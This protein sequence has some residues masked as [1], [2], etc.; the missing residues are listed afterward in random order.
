MEWMEFGDA[1]TGRRGLSVVEANFF[2]GSGNVSALYGGRYRLCRVFL[3]QAMA[4]TLSAAK[5]WE[6]NMLLT[7]ARTRLAHGQRF[8]THI[9]D[10]HHCR[11][12]PLTPATCC[13]LSL[14]QLTQ[15]VS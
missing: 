5:R 9:M 8:V 11:R 1:R 10:Y 12:H 14:D 3:R 15:F 6:E 4:G 2:A 13:Q 7:E